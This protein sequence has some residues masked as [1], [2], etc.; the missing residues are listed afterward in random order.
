MSRRRI[1]VVS[2]LS[3]ATFFLV[4]VAIWAAM[5]SRALSSA[6]ECSNEEH[7][8]ASS[9]DGKFKA[10]V[11]EPV[12]P[13]GAT[14]AATRVITLQQTAESDDPV[15]VATFE[16]TRDPT[17][18]WLDNDRLAIRGFAADDLFQKTQKFQ[19]VT[20]DYAADSASD[21]GIR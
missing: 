5:V 17:I 4:A 19:S 7:F 1:I 12:C 3:I 20:L 10:T 21:P 6:G 14:T 9:P 13:G 15:I 2:A 16:T 11:A 18:E 8:V